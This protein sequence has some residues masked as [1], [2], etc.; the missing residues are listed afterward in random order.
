ME[1][2]LEVRIAD[3][4]LAHV[5]ERVADVVHSGAA[6]ADPLRHQARAAVEIEL[7]HVG[8]MRGV[9]E[10]GERLHL[11]AAFELDPQ[12]PQPAPIECTR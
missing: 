3:A 6:L 7:A 10:E 8:G 9:G 2:A 11:A 1:D 4:E 12:Q 5:R